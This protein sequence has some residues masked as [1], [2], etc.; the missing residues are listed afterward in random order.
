MEEARGI[1]LVEPCTL[2]WGW[3]EFASFWPGTAIATKT[4]QN[5]SSDLKMEGWP[6]P[7]YRGARDELR[8]LAARRQSSLRPSRSRRLQAIMKRDE[9]F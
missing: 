8:A 4:P 3:Y 6:S 2:Y 7:A 9:P 5:E 1:V